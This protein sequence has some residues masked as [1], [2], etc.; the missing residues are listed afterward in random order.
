M[1]VIGVRLILYGED[2][3]PLADARAPVRTG[4]GISVQATAATALKAL[5]ESSWPPG[6][7]ARSTVEIEVVE[8]LASGRY[9]YRV[10][11]KSA[12]S[13]TDCLFECEVHAGNAVLAKT[14]GAFCR[15]E[16]LRGR[17]RNKGSKTGLHSRAYA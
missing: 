5:R 9:R 16:N 15:D 2:G 3:Y 8:E 12:G 11:G 6:R 17:A 7:V 13:H 4:R 10:L 1:R 14:I